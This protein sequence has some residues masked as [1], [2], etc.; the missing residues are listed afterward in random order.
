MDRND[1]RKWSLVI[2]GTLFPHKSCN[3][4]T[5]VSPDQKTQ[6]QTDH[7]MISR[8]W[9]ESLI[10]VRNKRSADVAKE[11]INAKLIKPTKMDNKVTI[12]K[13]YEQ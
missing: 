11:K 6:N 12:R 9:R 2:G 8:Q 13:E 5:W 7:T 10:D 1:G 4:I 3:K